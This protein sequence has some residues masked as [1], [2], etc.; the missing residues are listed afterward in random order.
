MRIDPKAVIGPYP[1]LL[2]RKTLRHL[3]SRLWW[4]LPELEAAAGLRL[5]GGRAMVKALR[6]EG[7]IEAAGRD[8]WKITQTGMTLCAA[9]AAKR[10][11]RATA[12]KALREFLARVERVNTDPYFLG[13]VTRVVLFGS[14]LQPEVKRL[15]DVD[16]AVEVASKEADFDDARVKNYERVEKLA[17]Q[18]HRFRNFLEREGCWYWEIFEFLKGHS[19]VIALADYATEKTFVLA[20]PHRVLLG[21]AEST[22]S[23]PSPRTPPRTARK[24]RP[25]DC[26]F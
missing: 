10:S 18:G 6:S 1:T 20:A 5:G 17:A 14:M 23:A 8:A 4:E 16:V 21:T 22:S 19:R 13:K 9:T 11:N 7:L 2:V 12:E 25:S 26:P 24:R 3:R 15:S